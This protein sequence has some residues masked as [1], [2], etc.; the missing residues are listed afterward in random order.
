[1]A[2]SI[3]LSFKG[4]F[5]NL[6]SYFDFLGLHLFAKVLCQE[7]SLGLRPFISSIESWN[8]YVTLVVFRVKFGEK[9]RLHKSTYQSVDTV[10]HLFL[11][12]LRNAALRLY[13]EFRFVSFNF[14]NAIFVR[15]DLLSFKC[16]RAGVCVSGG[17]VSCPLDA[18][19]YFLN[20]QIARVLRS[21]YVLILFLIDSAMNPVN[22]GY[23]G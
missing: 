10:S 22:V 7:T 23:R 21:T 12:C 15:L 9:A 20:C 11:K 18:T 19:C 2:C 1:M 16:F 6:L 8:C 14:N 5:L 3:R 13:C 4:T 17:P